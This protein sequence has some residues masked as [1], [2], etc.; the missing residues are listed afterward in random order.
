VARP[1]RRSWVIL[2]RTLL[3]V[4]HHMAVEPAAFLR[5]HGFRPKR[6]LGQNFLREAAV[7]RRI[8]AECE[9][10]AT[11]WILEI[12]AGYGSLT[13]LLA[14]DAARVVAVEVDAR[15][16]TLAKEYLMDLPN[17]QVL[18]ADVLAISVAQLGFPTSFLVVGNI[19]YYLTA[20]IL[21]HLLDVAPRPRRLVL[22]LQKEVAQ[23]ICA[24]PPDMSLLS[25]SVQAYGRPRL[26]ERLSAAAFYPVPRVDSAVIRIDTYPG[27]PPVG[28]DDLDGIFKLARAAFRQKRKNL[29]NAL[30]PALR[31]SPPDARELLQLAGIDPRRR[32][33]TLSLQEWHALSR[34]PGILQALRAGAP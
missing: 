26:V 10:A 5:A 4:K 17:V 7:L 29:A 27:G 31:A 1:I 16:A 20:P 21:R 18:C 8:A 33:Q 11:D 15:L 14:K 9:I 25:L 6:R 30:A 3:S 24:G 2:G 32:A 12:G 28:A 34:E 19:P 22:T 23:R 13:E